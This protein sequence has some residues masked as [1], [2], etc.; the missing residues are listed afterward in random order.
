MHFSALGK[1][2][3]AVK[4]AVTI[5]QN[6]EFRRLYAKGRSA[7]TPSLVMYCRKNGRGHNRLGITTSTKLGHAVV[8]NRARRR[9]RELFRL[10]QDRMQQRYDVLLVARGKTARVPHR[11]L[12]RD[13]DAA[14]SKLG[15]AVEAEEK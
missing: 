6:Y 12:Q 4:R 7:V 1:D 14:L 3:K 5:K 8:R 9:L 10:S 11:V 13:Y 2:V 15:L